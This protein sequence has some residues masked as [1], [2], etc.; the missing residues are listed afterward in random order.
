MQDDVLLATDFRRKTERYNAGLVAGFVSQRYN[1][2]SKMGIVTIEHA[3][4]S[5]PCIRIPNKMA[6]ECADWVLSYI[7]GNPVY[8]QYVGDG[9]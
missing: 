6:R 7:V 1:S 5:F 8:K 4:W 3:P 2:Q 9:N